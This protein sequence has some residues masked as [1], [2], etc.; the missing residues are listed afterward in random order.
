[1]RTKH[2]SDCDEHGIFSGRWEIDLT[3]KEHQKVEAGPEFEL[4]LF[5]LWGPRATEMR[6]LEHRKAAATVRQISR[7]IFVALFVSPKPLLH[8]SYDLIFLLRHVTAL[9]VQLF[10]QLSNHVRS[11]MG[12]DWLED[13][14]ACR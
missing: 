1:M 6:V 14:C 5:G 8:G 2:E 11:V 7:G 10:A 3:L 9:I 12:V 4:V 13:I